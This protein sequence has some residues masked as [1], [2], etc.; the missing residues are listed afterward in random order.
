MKK[1]TNPQQIIKP[2]HWQ[3]KLHYQLAKFANEL[4]RLPDAAQ[5]I[6]AR[7]RS[8]PADLLPMVF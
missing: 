4:D 5:A 8:V 1:R 2:H 6:R 7:P 3:W